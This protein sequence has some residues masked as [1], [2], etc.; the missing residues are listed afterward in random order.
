M[1]DDG[2]THYTPL[3]VEELECR[4]GKNTRFYHRITVSCSKKT[5]TFRIRVDET[6]EDRQIDPKTGRQR[7]NRTEHLRQLPPGTPAARRLK[8]FRQDS[9]S[10]HSR[11]DQAYPHERVPAYGARAALPIYIGYAWMN[12]SITRALNAMRS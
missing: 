2:K 3:P 10:I 4:E 9:E 11:F 6:D 8:G 1:A 7:F 5:H 12:N